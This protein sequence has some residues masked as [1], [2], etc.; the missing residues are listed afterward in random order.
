MAKKKK[1]YKIK[2]LKEFADDIAISRYA[3]F[4]QSVCKN[5]QKWLSKTYGRPS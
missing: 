4:Y 5:N 3:E 2:E 1:C